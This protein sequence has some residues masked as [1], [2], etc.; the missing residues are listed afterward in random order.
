[1]KVEFSWSLSFAYCLKDHFSYAIE[2][3]ILVCFLFLFSLKEWIGF[4]SL[5]VHWFLIFSTLTIMVWVL[6][7]KWTNIFLSKN[8]FRLR[9]H[10]KSIVE[11]IEKEA[12]EN[13][14]WCVICCICILKEILHCSSRL[15][16][17]T[18]SFPPIHRIHWTKSDIFHSHPC[19]VGSES[20][21]ISF[22]S[23][24]FE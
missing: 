5:L 12:I 11:I 3:T 19:I 4:L 15:I 18:F 16:W 8:L 13:C 1:L 6:F 7:E 21:N 14:Y 2:K 24:S 23:V 17:K 20:Y 22:I 10:W 9:K